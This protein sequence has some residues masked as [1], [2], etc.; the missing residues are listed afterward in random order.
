MVPPHADANPGQPVPAPEGQRFRGFRTEF[1]RALAGAGGGSL[2]AALGKYARNA[3]GGVAVGPRRFGTAY[4]AGG[5]LVGV[6]NDL[7]QGGTGAEF[8]G[9]DLSSLNGRPL[10]EAIQAI[11]Q[12]LAPENADADLIR[13]AVQEALA[14]VLPETASF[15]PADLDDDAL[16][17]VL[18]EF[19]T[20][21]IFQD[22]VN[23]AGDAWNKAPDQDRTIEAE[24]ELFD[25]VHAAVD[26][27]L[28]PALANGIQNMTRAQV[29]AKERL[30]MDA[31]WAEWEGNE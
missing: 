2:S 1:G 7:Q 14:E 27:H 17:A 24:N 20:R 18:I 5:A 9:I 21:I 11:A 13:I 19:F 3:T 6:L 10:A 12:A 16:I 30:A 22:I 8:A 26:R 29:E 31:I 23:D 15:E 4:T 28:S 25:I